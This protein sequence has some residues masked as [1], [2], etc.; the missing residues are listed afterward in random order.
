MEYFYKKWQFWG[1]KRPGR[2]KGQEER[3]WGADRSGF[4]SEYID[5]SSAMEDPDVR[6]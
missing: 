4:S 5:D 1:A 6:H 3:F 2:P